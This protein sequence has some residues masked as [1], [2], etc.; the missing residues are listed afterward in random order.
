LQGI[1]RHERLLDRVQLAG[2]DALDGRHRFTRRGARGHQTAHHR[3]A[4]HQHGAR[5]ADAGPAHQLRS[6]QIES[7]PHDIDEKALGIVGKGLDAA[8]DVIVLIYDLQG[9]ADGSF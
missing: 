5:A 1:V 4:L 8:V 2:A 3:H 7:V 6:R 9:S